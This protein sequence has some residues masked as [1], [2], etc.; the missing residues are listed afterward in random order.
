MRRYHMLAVIG[1]AAGGLLTSAWA[2]DFTPEE[3]RGKQLYREGVGADGTS[4]MA[5]IGQG[6]VTLSATKVPCASC[7]GPDGLGRPEAGVIPSNITWTHLTKPYGL[8]HDNG[9]SHP[10][11][12]PAAFVRAVTSGI[13]PA[14]NALDPAMP[15][16]T[17]NEQAAHD[18]AAYLKRLGTD[19][20]QGVGE[21]EVVVAAVV[22]S[23]GRACRGR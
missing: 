16:Y 1:L 22:P 10:P 8:R 2:G 11:Y 17:L 21:K 13:D 3:Q 9:R 23:G 18:L 4:P 20:D 6:S 7:H 14:G 19:S 12:T 5:T 15:R